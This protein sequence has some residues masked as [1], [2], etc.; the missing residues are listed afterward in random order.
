MEYWPAAA[1]G[2]AT[3]ES[4]A[5]VAAERV[6]FGSVS[7]NSDVGLGLESMKHLS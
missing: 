5:V 1:D 3:G 6:T 7:Q 2:R 4:L